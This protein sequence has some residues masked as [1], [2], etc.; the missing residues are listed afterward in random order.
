MLRGSLLAWALVH[1]LLNL[2]RCAFGGRIRVSGWVLEK[3]DANAPLSDNN[4][5]TEV[6][7]Q[8]QLADFSYDNHSEAKTQK[9]AD[10]H[11]AQGSPKTDHH[12]V[13]HRTMP[14]LPGKPTKDDRRVYTFHKIFHIMNDSLM[15]LNTVLFTATMAC[16]CWLMASR[17]PGKPSAEAADANA[18]RESDEI[19]KSWVRRNNRRAAAPR[20]PTHL[21]GPQPR[22]DAAA[23]FLPTASAAAASLEEDVMGLEDEVA[24]QAAPVLKVTTTSTC[25]TPGPR[26]ASP[27]AKSRASS[28]YDP[29]A[30][31]SMSLLPTL[32]PSPRHKR[33][34]SQG[35]QDTN[36]MGKRSTLTV[37]VVAPPSVQALH[38][39]VAARATLAAPASPTSARLPATPEA[40]E[41]EGMNTEDSFEKEVRIAARRSCPASGTGGTAAEDDFSDD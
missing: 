6:T 19:T 25:R 16:V 1:H 7:G 31:S 32:N 15:L 14:T 34:D 22:G 41:D 17:I 10:L 33:T 5:L 4:T 20:S 18:A 30:S 12:D 40:S 11:Q 38:K 3:S 8:Q 2:S 21:G 13:L 9:A 37:P 35:F 24:L 28:S 27:S 26:G 29:T 23:S 39:K 36:S